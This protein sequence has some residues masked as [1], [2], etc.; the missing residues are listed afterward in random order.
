MNALIRDALLTFGK[1]T[2]DAHLT[3]SQS[4]GPHMQTVALSAAYLRTAFI[5]FDRNA[6]RSASDVLIRRSQLHSTN[7]I[8]QV[9]NSTLK[10]E[11]HPTTPSEP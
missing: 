11:R 3:A 10:P 8:S 5:A 1:S 2:E 4:R 7:A 6:E 9:D